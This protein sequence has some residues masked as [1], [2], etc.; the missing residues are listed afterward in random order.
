MQN[1]E[2]MALLSAGLHRMS[3]EKLEE[4]AVIPFPKSERRAFLLQ[5]FQKLFVIV[6]SFSFLNE[7][8]VDG[9]YMTKKN[10]PSDIDILLLIDL[11]KYD[12]V[13]KEFARKFEGLQDEFGKGRAC[14]DIKYGFQY[15]ASHANAMDAKENLK[16][17]Q[18]WF[19]TTRV[20][21]QKG[22]AVIGG[23]S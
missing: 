13:T 17:Y 7:I 4:L 21:A 19:G 5:G 11:V 10:N 3:I 9:S 22:I 18:N 14:C 15:P 6:R 23:G 12:S 1:E 8:W 2:E 20:G 16:F